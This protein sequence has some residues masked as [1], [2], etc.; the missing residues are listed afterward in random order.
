M[1]E[2]DRLKKQKTS[3]PHEHSDQLRQTFDK[4]NFFHFQHSGI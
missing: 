1:N 3:T 2:N 4:V